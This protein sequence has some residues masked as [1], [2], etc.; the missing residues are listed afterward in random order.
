MEGDQSD[1]VDEVLLLKQLRLDA[2]GVSIA[3]LS[4]QACI[5]DHV[6]HV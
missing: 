6:S 4:Q 2:L 1:E 3:N 5:I